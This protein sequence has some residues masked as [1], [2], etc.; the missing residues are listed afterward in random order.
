M[1][2]SQS[3]KINRSDDQNVRQNGFLI[4][5]HSTSKHGVSPPATLTNLSFQGQRKTGQRRA[6]FENEIYPIHAL[7]K[8]AYRMQTGIAL[9]KS[10]NSPVTAR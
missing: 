4:F 9:I 7:S 6:L 1:S 3:Q 10:N 5:Y 2:T 8:L